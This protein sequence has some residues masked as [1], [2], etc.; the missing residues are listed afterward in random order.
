M[1]DASGC[2]RAVTVCVARH[3]SGLAGVVQRCPGVPAV[4]GGAKER[5]ERRDGGVWSEGPGAS[6]R[7]RAV[8]DYAQR[9]TRDVPGGVAGASSAVF[10]Y[11][12]YS[13]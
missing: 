8:Q 2:G 1:R 12:L 7:R 4:E 13:K 6:A 9:Y 5:E 10:K 11:G 3:A